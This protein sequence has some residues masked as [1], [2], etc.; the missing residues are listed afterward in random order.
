MNEA[1]PYVEAVHE[2]YDGEATGVGHVPSW[3]VIDQRYRNRYVFAGLMPRQP[4]PGRWY[5][6]GTVGEG[7]L[8]RGA[9]RR[10]RG[11][12]GR[13]SR[14]PSSGST[15]S[16]RTGVDEDF[17]R[18]ESAYDK[19]Y[20]DP[21]VKPNPSLHAI[22]QAPFYAV[23]IVPGD[24]GTKG[25]LVTDERA[26]VLRADGS[27]IAG[28]YAA[29]N[30]LVG[31]HGPHL[32]RPRRDHRACPGVRL[33]G[34]RGHRRSSASRRRAPD[35]HRPDRR[36]R[37]RPRLRTFSW[38]SSDV[39]LY[40]LGIGAGA[41]PGDNLDPAVLRW[42][43][44]ARRPA[45]AAVVR[46]RGADVPRDRGAVGRDARRARSTSPR[47]CTARSRSPCTRR[48]RPPAR[49]RQRTTLTDVW[50]KGKAAVIWQEATVTSDDGADLWTTRSSIFVRGEG[51][52][53]GDRGDLGAG[54]AAGPGAGRRRRR[55]PS[56]RSRR[57]STGCAATATRCTPTRTFAKAA[58]FPAPI[59][60]GLCS[61][62][63][64]LRELTRPCSAATP[65]GS[66][67]S[68]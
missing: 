64:V 60:H 22:D 6:N 35:A 5:K 42:T 25:G 18:G 3:M 61:Y 65:A 43:A 17:H 28:L 4:F 66:A 30:V 55:T 16:P 54:R 26:R 63:I 24:L 47:S 21:T 31:R 32:R 15:A 62:G 10:D 33:P 20:S 50:D 56:R 37:R 13:R 2:I 51:G 45:G 48:S 59:L 12:G 27:V 53:G 9:R 11:A 23:K 58:G 68:R 44:D 49:P 19:Y 52:F 36:D 29:G 40:H 67:A 57:C 14:P 39:L 41:R 34:R 38:S 8:D 1:L 46:R 7:R